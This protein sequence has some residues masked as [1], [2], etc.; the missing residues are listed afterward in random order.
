MCPDLC[1]PP[2]T[3]RAPDAAPTSR[4]EP[5]RAPARYI[6][7]FDSIGKGDTAVV[8]GKGA[9]LGEMAGAGFP[10]PPGFVVTTDAYGRFADASG[11]SVAIR[12]RLATLDVD[13]PDQLRL[14]SDAI[15][16]LVRDA[17]M[18]DDVGA[19]ILD[20]YA[21]L[22]RDASAPGEFV[23]VRSSGTVEDTAQFSF[24]GMFQS[25]LNVQG[26]TVNTIVIVRNPLTGNFNLV[27]I[28]SC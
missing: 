8:G 11:V 10:I 20:A 28:P 26:G 17:P 27:S 6:R 15:Q 16:T 13:A 4:P 9:N 3:S 19:E 25:T 22:S 5:S 12:E 1:I 24:A 7:W 23:A 21:V 18:P 2:T 14:T